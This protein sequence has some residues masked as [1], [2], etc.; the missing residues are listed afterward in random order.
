MR[1]PDAP[2]DRLIVFPGSNTTPGRAQ[3]TG[4]GPAR[5]HTSLRGASLSSQ[6]ITSIQF[7]GGFEMLSHATRSWLVGGCLAVTTVL[8]A[9]SVVLGAQLSTTALLLAGGVS[10]AAIIVLIGGGATKPIVAEVP[11]GIE[12][13]G[14]T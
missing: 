3:R 9:A 2:V 11:Y 1:D 13:D 4:S 7:A 12:E 6:S 5:R 10:S 14:R 8:A